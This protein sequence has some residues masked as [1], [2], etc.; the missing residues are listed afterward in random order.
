[1]VELS[2]NEVK[3]IELDILSRF[4][5]FCRSNGLRYS[6]AY[7]TLLGAIRHKG[8]IPWDDDIDVWMPRPDYELFLSTFNDDRYVF[9]CHEKCD[10]W[11]EF[12]KLTDRTTCAVPTNNAGM[13]V[14]IDVVP[15]D[16]LPQNPEKYKK[17][18]LWLFNLFTRMRFVNIWGKKNGLQSIVYRIIELIYP[19]KKLFQR[20][21]ATKQ[22]F[23]F[24]SSTNSWD[25][26]HQFQ[27]SDFDETIDVVFE[28][29][30]FRSFANYDKYLRDIYGDY[31]Q[32]PPVEKRVSGHNYKFYK[33]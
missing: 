8:F 16:G 18:I 10:Y 21:E 33:Q 1:M 15:V 28:D 7:G 20:L 9:L 31:M 29:R 19:T 13:G 11:L 17:K 3:Q 25:L 5:K 27:S 2:L 23:P 24:E 22:F 6:L 30:K 4:D 12:G 14:F 26:Y 32:L